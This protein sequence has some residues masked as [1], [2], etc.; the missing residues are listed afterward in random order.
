MAKY[1]EKEKLKKL[2]NVEVEIL[3]E[4]NRICNKHNL[5]YFLSYGTLLGA[6]RHQGFIP[7]DDDLD[8]SMP[9]EDYEK[10][11]E[12]AEDELNKE[13]YID[14]KN[15]NDKYY[16]NFTKLRKKNTVFEQDFQVNYDGP[17]GI[18]VDIFPIDEIKK[19][20]SKLLFIQNKLDSTIFRICHYKS[21]FFLSKKLLLIKKLIF[22]F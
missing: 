3:D 15:T 11:I 2:H 10:F 4:F 12:I 18:W 9:R 13:Y 1:M 16:L 17:K 8:V 5:Q 21:G 7:W 19:E 22:H 20:N 14:N 6:V